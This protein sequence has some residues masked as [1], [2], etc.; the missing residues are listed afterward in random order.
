MKNALATLLYNIP[1]LA[2][3]AAAVWCIDA[4]HPK[5]AICLIVISLLTH[6]IPQ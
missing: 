3:L 1:S 4:D 2:F 5:F 6:P